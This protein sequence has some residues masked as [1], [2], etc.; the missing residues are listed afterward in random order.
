MVPSKIKT[1]IVDDEPHARQLISTLLAAQQ[2]FEI[3]AECGDGEKAIAAIET[4]KPDLVFLDI[5]MPELDGFDVLRSLST[6]NLPMVIFVTA[7]DQYAVKAFEVHAL[8]YLLKPFDDERFVD[9][10]DRVRAQMAASRLDDVRSKLTDLIDDVKRDRPSAE[11]LLIKSAGR[12]T[13]V[14]ED[15]IDWI[16]AAGNYM[17]IH[18]GKTVHLMRGTMSA[19]EDQLKSERF[20]RIH[21]SAIVNL[22]S[23]RELLPSHKGEFEVVLDNGER[24]MLSRKYRARLEERLGRPL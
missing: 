18:A 13:F 10:L 6:G 8:D 4:K 23:I 3:V 22:D 17:R 7:F 11:R 20:V 1:I 9:A 12:I 21:R 19:M 14:T 15:E 24:L 16:E 5:Q 2:D